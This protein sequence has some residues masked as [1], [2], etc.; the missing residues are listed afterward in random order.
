MEDEEW[1]SPHFLLHFLQ[2]LLLPSSKNPAEQ[3]H[4]GIV[5]LLTLHTV[6]SVID[7]PQSPHFLSQILH[8]G[9]EDD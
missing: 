3:V 2:S 4:D 1:H 6:Q 7:S 5:S 8:A 9:A